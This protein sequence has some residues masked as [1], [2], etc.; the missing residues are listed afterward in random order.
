VIH[1]GTGTD[2]LLELQRDTGGDVIGVDWRLPLDRAR[3]RLGN[4]VALQGNLDPHLLSAPTERLRQAVERVLVSAGSHPGYIFNLGHG[5]LPETPPEAVSQ[6]V[7][8]V[9]DY[10][11]PSP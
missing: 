10:V 8:W 2:S 6:V 3:A 1:F 4:D 9:H 5:I 11:R 7:R